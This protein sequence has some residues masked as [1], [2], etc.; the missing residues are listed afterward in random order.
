MKNILVILVFL[1]AFLS[2]TIV[3]AM[4]EKPT[5]QITKTVIT[6]TSSFQKVFSKK[7]KERKSIRLLHLP[8]RYV[9]NSMLM[10]FAELQSS[11]PTK[12]QENTKQKSSE[13][14]SFIVRL[15][16]AVSIIALLIT[17][18]LLVL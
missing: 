1:L 12:K 3:F 10:I 8:T 17:L 15:I 16:G 11:I 4:A 14:I 9:F 5:Q 6:K 13:I 7:I 2:N 18:V